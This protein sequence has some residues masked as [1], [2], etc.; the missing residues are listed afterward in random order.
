MNCKVRMYADDVVLYTDVTSSGEYSCTLQANLNE[1]SRW[2]N[3]WKMLVNVKKCAIMRMT[4]NKHPVKPTYYLNSVEIPA[5]QEFKYLGV[6]IS[7]VCNWQ[8]HIKH[9][10]SK[11]N[12]MLRF[13]KRNF[14]GCPPAVKETVMYH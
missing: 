4:R 14:R 12:Q 6:Y 3:D 1:L 8:Q 7:N 9:V 10:A 11:G 5:V 2:C 13:I